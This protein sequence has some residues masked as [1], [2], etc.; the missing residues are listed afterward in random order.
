[1][2]LGRHI[3]HE[4]GSFG[5]K[6]FSSLGY[7]AITSQ[8]T[9][10]KRLRHAARAATNARRQVMQKGDVA[11]CKLPRFILSAASLS[12]LDKSLSM[13]KAVTSVVEKGTQ[14]Q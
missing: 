7:A 14:S 5:T 8:K 13:E 11:V 12:L 6:A 9:K 1:M 10:N 4:L 2:R 3:L